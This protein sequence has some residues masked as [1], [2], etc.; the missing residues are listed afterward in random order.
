MIF[1]HVYSCYIHDILTILM[2]VIFSM[3][4]LSTLCYHAVYEMG[5]I[6]KT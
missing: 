6:N 2:Y 5:Y 3:T 1:I 4:M